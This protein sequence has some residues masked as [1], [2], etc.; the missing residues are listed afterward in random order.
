MG[1]AETLPARLL[2]EAG[3]SAAVLGVDFPLGVPRAYAERYLAGTAN[4]PAFLRG[5]LHRPGLFQ[6]CATLDEIGPWRP[7]YPARGAAGMTRDSHAQALGLSGAAALSRLC[8]RAT[9]ERPAGAPLFWT[10]GANQSGKAALHA[11][12][13]CLL[14]SLDQPS[15]PLLWPFHGDL[16]ALLR[17]GR[18]AIAETYPAEALRQL[19]LRVPGSKRRQADRLAVV[20]GL[21]EAMAGL[22]ARPDAAL[23]R[24][25]QSGFGPD[26]D[27]EDR[28]DCVVGCLCIL[29]VLAGRRPDGVP[30]D[31]ALR[32]WEGWVLGQTAMPR[33]DVCVARAGA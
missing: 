27:G 9:R 3:G 7:F 29:T 13:C 10:L 16:L 2:A 1:D 14:P 33:D 24:L 12:R 6:V 19:G 21:Q 20:P 18:I 8:D 23:Q 4:F 22:D 30:D 25:M 11:W 17:P 32:R 5:L 31:P 26:A 28:F 15:P